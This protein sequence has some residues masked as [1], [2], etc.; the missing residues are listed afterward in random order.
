MESYL[1]FNVG[2]LGHVD[3]GKTSLAKA[4]STTAST[5]AFDKNPQSQMRGITIDLGFSSFSVDSPDHISKEGYK[6]LQFTLVDCP[7]HASLIRTVIGGAQIIDAMILVIDIVKGIQTQTAECLI[8]GEILCKDM[9]VVL[10]KIDL[11]PKDK[12]KQT[13]DKVS[14]KILNT[15]KN[16]KFS[17]TK[18]VPVSANP[19]GIDSDGVPIGIEDLINTMQDLAYIP[20]RAENCEFVFSVDHCFGIKGQGTIITG[21]ILQGSVAVNDNIE[22]PTLKVTKK[23]KSIQMFRQPVEKAIQGDRIGLC[24]TQFD[25]KLLERSI[26]G[27]PGYI[28][29]AYGF[30]AVIYRISYYKQ[31]VNSKAKFHISL[32]HDTVMSTVT[33][34]GTNEN[35][36]LEN[37]FNFETE[38]PF[39]AELLDVNKLESSETYKPLQQFALIEFERVVPVRQ[40]SSFIASKLDM[41]IHS[42]MCR[43]AF[44]GTVLY[45]LLDNYKKE[46]YPKLKVYKDKLREGIVERMNNDSELI[47]KNLVKKGTDITLFQG[48]KVSLCSGEKGLIDSYFGQSGKVKIRLLNDLN[49]DTKKKLKAIA[50]SKKKGKKTVDANTVGNVPIKV[51]LKFKKYIFNPNKRL[52]QTDP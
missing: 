47:V 43:L 23:V 19:S 36:S 51:I 17:S 6:K 12:R 11:V 50:D 45:P 7:G 46:T 38:Y 16:T 32:G 27:S 30:L 34:F 8:I 35:T 29:C 42:N 25:P 2:I 1:N 41:D 40:N 15:L 20:K 5:A 22:I 21:T 49:D 48:L 26:I 28:H 18:V 39:Q 37:G 3:S 52:V 44:W 9:I 24:V 31:S 13:I 10:N 4:L 33:F 14:K